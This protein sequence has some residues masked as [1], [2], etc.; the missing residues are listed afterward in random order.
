MTSSLL[1]VNQKNSVRGVRVEDKYCRKVA[2][3]LGIKECNPEIERNWKNGMF[4]FFEKIKE[5]ENAKEDR[6]EYGKV[7]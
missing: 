4:R 2:E 5:G 1:N 3:F 7:G 6:R